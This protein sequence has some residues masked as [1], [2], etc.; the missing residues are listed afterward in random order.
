MTYGSRITQR[1]PP[2]IKPR[3]PGVYIASVNDTIED[4]FQ[5]WDG[6]T[7]YRGSMNSQKAALQT[8][9]DPQSHLVYWRGLNGEPK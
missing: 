4:Q 9:P 5:R 1:F 3:R 2:D 6:K 8:E 7:W